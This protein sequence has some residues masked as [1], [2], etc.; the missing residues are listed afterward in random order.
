MIN[1]GDAH[2]EIQQL[3]YVI[4]AAEQM[5]FS[6]AA[7]LS[8]ITQSCLSQ[9]IAKLED[10]LGYKLFE[11][12]TRNVFLTAQGERFVLQAHKVL[13]DIEVLKLSPHPVN[14]DLNGTLRIGAISSMATS[15]FSRLIAGFSSH[16][17]QIKLNLVQSGS[18]DL[19]EKL[20]KKEVDVVFITTQP[21]ENIAGCQTTPLSIFS[22]FLAVPKGHRLAQRMYVKL[23]ELWNE[24]FVFHDQNLA[25]YD[26]CLKACQKAG[27]DPK[28]ICTTTHTWFRYYMVEAGLGLGFFPYEDFLSFPANRVSR[29]RIQPAIEP[30]LAMATMN[31]SKDRPIV[32]TFYSFVQMWFQT[33]HSRLNERPYGQK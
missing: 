17:P 4:R 1:K 18:L 22:Y 25:M 16:Y 10:E 7:E 33:H 32:N 20:R 8:C 24:P 15:E 28:I 3:V 5:N 26:I 13:E 9:Q 31:E 2:M 27:F 14:D 21:G 11:R 19:V 23:E 12:T 30:L 29:L 6:K